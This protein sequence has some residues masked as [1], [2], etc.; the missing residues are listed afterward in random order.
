PGQDFDITFR[1]YDAAE[2]GDPIWVETHS[3]VPITRGTFNVSLGGISPLDTAKVSDPAYLGLEVN[4]SG[5][6]APRQ[7][8][9]SSAFAMRADSAESA[10][11]ASL[12]DDADRLGG[13]D[14]AEYAKLT[15]LDGEYT[16]IS[17]LEGLCVTDDELTAVL[18]EESY[19]NAGDLAVYLTENGFLPGAP[20][21]GDFAD[22]VGI[23]A[24]LIDGDDDTLGMMSCDGGDI[25]R[26]DGVSWVC[27]LDRVLTEEEVDAMVSDNGYALTELLAAVATSGSYND[28][29][30]LPPALAQL[31][32]TED[33]GL[34][35]GGTPIVD[36]NGE[37]IG[38]PTGLQGP[39]GD[40]G[41]TGDVGEKGDTG[42]KGDKGDTGDIGEKGDKGDTGDQGLPGLPGV[43]VASAEVNPAGQLVVTLTNGAV[44]TSDSLLGEKGD[45]GDPG[46]T[47]LQGLQGPKG[48]AG[49][50]GSQGP[51]GDQ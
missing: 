30:D 29:T 41:D 43:G 50:Q 18:I 31:S 48:D 20:F 12:A 11:V 49:Q 25:I 37:W 2:G 3:N 14:A 38:A 36:T 6:M 33:G 28:L 21:S 7:R 17:D 44:Y 1:L 46:E 9:V 23:P 39:K 15:D 47:G 32:V 16:K 51:K 45:K 24:G 22:L 35:F 42:E 10:E 19:L 4:G 40:K 8:L 26:F 5:E 13:L 27:D 34:A